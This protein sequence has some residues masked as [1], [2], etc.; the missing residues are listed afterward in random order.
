MAIYFQKSKS[1]KKARSPQWWVSM[2]DKYPKIYLNC[3]DT[4]YEK[5][6]MFQNFIKSLPK[7]CPFERQI[8]YNDTL[9]L[10]IPA[11]CTFNPL[12]YQLMSLKAQTLK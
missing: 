3:I 8:W 12:F 1:G 4:L 11:L 10:Y 9:I 6:E 5:S 7:K 2:M